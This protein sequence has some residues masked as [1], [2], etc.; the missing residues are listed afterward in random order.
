M[1]SRYAWWQVCAIFLVLGLA[2]LTI[3]ILAFR[4]QLLFA[5]SATFDDFIRIAAVVV[6]WPVAASIIALRFMGRFS[7]A[8][9]S[10]LKGLGHVKLPGGIELQSVQAPSGSETTSND[11]PD[12]LVLSLEQQNQIRTTIQEIEQQRDNSD[13]RR[14][15]IEQEFNLMANTSIQWKFQYLSLLFVP[16]T[17][18]VLY[19]FSTAPPQTRASY[20]TAWTT[21]IPDPSQ[22]EI[23]LNILLQYS[24]LKESDGVIRI[25]PH[26]YSFLQFIGMIPPAPAAMA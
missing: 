22:R 1:S 7:S 12:A 10:Y 24:M 19:W 18:N 6:S 9:E 8:I 5:P 17:K 13:A 26:G 3:P 11:P 20:D 15:A 4:G 23:V 21:T 2:V 14:T 25:D 16:T